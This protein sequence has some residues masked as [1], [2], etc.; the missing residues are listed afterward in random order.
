MKKCKKC[1]QER[2]LSEFSKSSK[3]AGGLHPYCKECRAEY[4][5]IRMSDPEKLEQHR[6]RG[7]AYYADPVNRER[8][9]KLTKERLSNPDAKARAREAV[10]R[11]YERDMAD[12]AKRK[13]RS[14][15]KVL[16][17]RGITAE[18]R[19]ALFAE[20]EHR[21]AICGTDNPAGSGNR[22]WHIDHCHT[23]GRVRGI[24]CGNCNNALGFIGERSEAAEAMIEYI[25]D[26]C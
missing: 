24:L 6:A 10:R 12:P 13:A 7:R 26:R 2:E 22:R 16:R 25:R 1:L 19:D 11:C 20:Q 23:T 5:R 18:Q 15:A 21:C 9:A 8:Q 3:H 4:H 14:D 17:R